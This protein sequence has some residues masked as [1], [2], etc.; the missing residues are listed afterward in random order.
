ME[1][2]IHE[3]RTLLREQYLLKI[4]RCLE[5][6]DDEAIWWRPNPQVNSVGNLVLHLSGNLRHWLVSGVG[7]VPSSRDRDAEFALDVRVARPELLT[8]LRRAV[9]DAD[10]VLAELEPHTLLTEKEIRGRNV[11]LLYTI[12]HVTEHFSMHTGQIILLTKIIL[13][14]DL[15]F[16]DFSSGAPIYNWHTPSKPG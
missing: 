10:K 6:L 16:Y 13:A 2:F 15:N 12:M 1:A 7:G 14:E 3:C 8:T 9:Q 11:T 5:Y 4:E